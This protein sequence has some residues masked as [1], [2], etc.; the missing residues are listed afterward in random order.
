MARL[1]INRRLP[2]FVAGKAVAHVQVYDALRGG[3]LGQITVA[4]RTGHVRANMRRMIEPDMRVLAVVVDAHP[5]NVFMTRL[6]GG[7]FFDLGLVGSN[8]QVAGHAKFYA[9]DGGVGPHVGARVAIQALQVIGQMRFVREGD[10]L[11]GL[12][13]QPQEIAHGGNGRVVVSGKDV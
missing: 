11:H 3:L 4:R 2:L 5:G 6:K 8:H 1:A 12:R 7:D 9:G 13:S 10:G